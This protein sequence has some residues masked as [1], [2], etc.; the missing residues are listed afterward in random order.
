MD[1]GSI[2][3]IAVDYKR[4]RVIHRPGKYAEFPGNIGVV[5]NARRM[6]GNRH[7]LQLVAMCIQHLTGQV[8]LRRK[9]QPEQIEGQDK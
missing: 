6:S 5:G 7:I 3:I 9:V 1:G 4:Q 8:I 2:G